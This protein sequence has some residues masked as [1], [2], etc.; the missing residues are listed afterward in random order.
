MNDG[1]TF[2]FVML[3]LALCGVD[4]AADYASL[5]GLFD[6]MWGFAAGL[7]IGGL[8]GWTTAKGVIELRRKRRFAVGMEE[9]LTLGLIAVSYGL[10][11]LAHGIG[12][13][14]VFAAGVAV[15]NVES[16]TSGPEKPEEVLGSIQVSQR[17]EVAVDPK[18][19]PAY[20]TEV[21]LGFN[22]QLEHLAEFAMVLIIGVLLSG[23]GLSVEGA[24]LAALI[25]VVVRPLSVL[26]SLYGIGCTRLQTGL[27]AWFGIRGIGSL[28]YLLYA[29]Q[30]PWLPDLNQRFTSIVLTVIAMSIVIHGISATPLMELYA[31]R[32]R[33]ARRTQMNEEN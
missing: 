33:L 25:F 1:T 29:L 22:Q 8:A 4:Q 21:V 11:H 19:A 20:M 2:P 12:F 9:F 10:A 30:F 23:T 27:M 28:Y 13:V 24:V 14:A 7:A 5:R 15:R 6:A 17:E 18:K 31:K 32:N 16:Q 26:P 3:G